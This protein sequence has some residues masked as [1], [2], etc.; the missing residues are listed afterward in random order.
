MAHPRTIQFNGVRER[1]TS[2]V[3]ARPIAT[4][5]ATKATTSAISMTGPIPGM[6]RMSNGERRIARNKSQMAAQIA[7]Q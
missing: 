2:A 3:P 4:I 1:R 5:G 6:I 7:R